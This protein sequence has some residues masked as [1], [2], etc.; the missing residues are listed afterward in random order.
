MRLRAVL[1]SIAG[2]SLLMG[3]QNCGAPTTLD[4]V[5]GSDAALKE[6]LSLSGRYIVSHFI[7][8]SGCPDVDLSEG[9]TCSA[10][11][12]ESAAVTEQSIEFM[13]DGTL[14]I[15]G[16]CNTYYSTYEMYS[17]EEGSNAAGRFAV[18]NISGS[19][20]ACDGDAVE[21]ESV[22]IHRL[23]KAVGIKEDGD[24][25]VTIQTNQSSEV[26]FAKQ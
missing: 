1:F 2:F 18:K 19:K 12:S 10:E 26:R 13:P 25:S 21:E 24:K 3:F 17:L 7:A 8:N 4:S 5:S 14:I 11:Y 20:N 22:L 16:A 15:E 23:S 9:L 6:K